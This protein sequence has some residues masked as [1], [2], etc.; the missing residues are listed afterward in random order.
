MLNFVRKYL[1]EIVVFG[2]ITATLLICVAPSATWMNTDSDGIHDVYA[3]KNLYLSHKTSMPLYLLV[4]NLF[5]RIPFGTDFWNLALF[6]VFATVGACIFIYLSIKEHLKDNPN[7]RYFALIGVL[8]YGGSALVI[9]QSIIV[10]TYSLVTMLGVGAYYFYLRKWWK[11]CALMLGLG[12]SVHL[13]AGIPLIVLFIASK[14]L[15]RIKPIAIVLACLLLYLYIPLSPILSE[16]P[17]MWGNRTLGD[18]LRDLGG[19]YNSLFG[20][21]AI[22]DL[23]KRLLDTLGLLVVSLALALAPIVWYFRKNKIV[24][25]PLFWLF[26]SPILM[27]II[28][29]PPQTY[30]YLMPTI[31]MG[32]IIAGI[33]LPRLHFRWSLAVL[34]VA[35]LLTIYNGIYF[36]IGRTLDSELSA[37]KYYDEELEKVPDGQILMPYY[38]WEWAAIYPY[39]KENDREII[40][41][42]MDILTSD[43][44]L[45][46][47]EEQGIEFEWYSNEQDRLVRQSK[48]ALSIVEL[49]DNVWTTKTTI[50]ETYGVEVVLAEGNEELLY[51]EPTEPP[52]QIHWKP[53]NPY[54]IIT[55]AI[56][57]SE[58]KFI[59]MSNWNVG[60]F[61]VFG[62]IGL[63][64]NWVI[65]IMPS[66]KKV[67]RETVTK[68]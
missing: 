42:C 2:L 33:M 28:G 47:I 52:G 46:M 23:P 41:V 37:T 45:N 48:I 8:I 18:M 62:C 9:S 59:T 6:S 15:R 7:S 36:D 24:H 30:V 39:N 5:T 27:F 51:R 16:Q 26:I 35:V 38:G 17:D 67:K 68:G 31:A 29:L 11:R 4:G 66:K 53:S 56:E 55:G 49:N 3:A 22:Y 57:V 25:N 58:W 50:P 63:I 65:F 64:F 10:E 14:E 21:L 12:L 20:S 34:A 61:M 44:Y 54:D 43:T 19:T 60:F 32:A 1:L 40:P 13:L